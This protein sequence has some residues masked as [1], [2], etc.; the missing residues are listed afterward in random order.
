MILHRHLAALGLPV[1]RLHGVIGR[2]GGWSA[3]ADRPVLGQA[4][5]TRFLAGLAGDIVVRPFAP[6][7]GAG[8]RVLR[9]DGSGF[10]DLDGRRSEPVVVVAEAYAHPRFELFVVQERVT[11]HERMRALLPGGALP[12]ARV[13]TFVA[14]DGRAQIV[15]AC[16]MLPVAG[17]R[18][19]APDGAGR[20]SVTVGIDA[21]TGA[22][23]P[24]GAAPGGARWDEGER[25]PDW[26]AACALACR[27]AG[28]LMP[29]RT[30]AWD[31]A[32]TPGGPVV[33]G[34]DSRYERIESARFDEALRAMERALDDGGPVALEGAA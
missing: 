10:I 20:D 21:S 4:A 19:G 28:L 11:A 6:S 18:P 17:D 22:L 2:A 9:R 7:S 33:V 34:A 30:I 26:G 8:M 13:T 31:I 15:H 1:P 5:A 12:T 25:L 16:L 23:E 14:D 24:R 32:L 27:G 3:S 29:Q